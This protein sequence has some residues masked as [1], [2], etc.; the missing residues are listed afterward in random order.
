[1]EVGGQKQNSNTNSFSKTQDLWGIK[2]LLMGNPAGEFANKEIIRSALDPTADTSFNDSMKERL[3][4][5]IAQ[6]HTGDQFQSMGANSRGAAESRAVVGHEQDLINSLQGASNADTAYRLG[7]AA[8]AQPY[9]GTRTTGTGSSSG[10]QGQ[11]GITCCFILLEGLNGELPWYVRA[12]RDVYH[13][14]MPDMVIGYRRLSVWLVPAMRTW[15]PVKRFVNA[16]MVKPLV[17]IGAGMAG[18]EP[19][20]FWHKPVRNFYGYLFLALG[21]I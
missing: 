20:M 10:T 9:Q 4:E 17:H 18:V 1:M 14:T 19:V 16:V 3:G 7:T 11:A 5:G 8:A 6:A 13:N 21:K 12:I 15:A 2:D